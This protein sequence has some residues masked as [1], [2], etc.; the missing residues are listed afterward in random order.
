MLPSNPSSPRAVIHSDSVSTKNKNGNQVAEDTSQEYPTSE[1]VK[2]E[3][4]EWMPSDPSDLDDSDDGLDEIFLTG[5]SSSEEE[6]PELIP[7]RQDSSDIP[8]GSGNP[9]NQ[10]PSKVTAYDSMLWEW[11]PTDASSDEESS[12]S[13]S[14]KKT[15]NRSISISTIPASSD[16]PDRTANKSVRHKKGR[17]FIPGQAPQLS[18]ARRAHLEVKEKRLRFNISRLEAERERLGIPIGMTRAL[19]F[20]PAM[21]LFAGGIAFFAGTIVPFMLTVAAMDCISECITSWKSDPENPQAKPPSGWAERGEGLSMLPFEMA[22]IMCDFM[23]TGR[24]QTLTD[25]MRL[26]Q[27]PFLSAEETQAELK[28]LYNPNRLI[29]KGTSYEQQAQVVSTK[30]QKKDFYTRAYRCYNGALKIHQENQKIRQE[31]SKW[32]FLSK[33]MIERRDCEAA[34]LTGHEVGELKS[35]IQRITMGLVSLH[36]ASGA[37][38]QTAA[39]LVQESAVGDSA[40]LEATVSNLEARKL[41]LEGKVQKLSPALMF[42]RALAVIPFIAIGA[43]GLP[44]ALTALIAA[45]LG[46]LIGLGVSLTGKDTGRREEELGFEK[47]LGFAMLPL[48]IAEVLLKFIVSGKAA[49]LDDVVPLG[50]KITSFEADAKLIKGDGGKVGY[51]WKQGLRKEYEADGLAEG[52]PA[53][54]KLYQEAIRFYKIANNQQIQE[55]YNVYAIAKE[56]D[57]R[58]QSI[59]AAE[60][61][62]AKQRENQQAVLDDSATLE[63]DQKYLD[64]ISGKTPCVPALFAIARCYHSLGNDP[65]SSLYIQALKS[66]EVEDDSITSL[67]EQ[68]KEWNKERAQ[69][70]QLASPD[71]STNEL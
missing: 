11:Q 12:S 64:N 28:E 68:A 51:F 69:V 8:F 33:T 59:S 41:Y 57:N 45:P 17:P 61:E 31:S 7:N 9:I 38:G 2:Q 50:W 16:A 29:Q 56:G 19:T 34:V 58:A 63:Q 70:Q 67:L 23:F 49:T 26:D 13:E 5:S 20:F 27:N 3:Q 15:Q 4:K 6:E 22:L 37:A 54:A 35:S 66:R 14:S 32:H 25:W 65:A 24:T 44:F 1:D 40:Q 39:D 55:K 43:L 60:R 62:A 30:Q 18:P 36:A 47:G 48:A 10:P 21:A 52:D 46:W 71:A 53:R 42:T